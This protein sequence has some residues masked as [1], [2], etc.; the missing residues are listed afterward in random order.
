MLEGRL[1]TDHRLHAAHARREFR[2]S[3]VQFGVGGKLS[4]VTMRA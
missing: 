1:L 4:D 2:V 3:D